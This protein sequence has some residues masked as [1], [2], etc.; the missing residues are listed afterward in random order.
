MSSD[1][2]SEL[3]AAAPPINILEQQRQLRSQGPEKHYFSLSDRPNSPRKQTLRAGSESSLKP[4]PY[5][6]EFDALEDAEVFI[7]ANRNWQSRRQ[8]VETAENTQILQAG[9]ENIAAH[10]TQND[11]AVVQPVQV[12]QQVNLLPADGANNQNIYHQ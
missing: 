4:L 8:Q 5:D 6:A 11:G 1:D 2:L 12:V 9:V 7:S 10:Q 3:G